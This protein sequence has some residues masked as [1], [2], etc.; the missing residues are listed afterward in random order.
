MMFFPPTRSGTAQTNV[1]SSP[2]QSPVADMSRP[3]S[4][5]LSR[6]NGHQLTFNPQPVRLDRNGESQHVQ[7][8]TLVE[9]PVERCV[10]GV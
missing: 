7:R 10:S 1:E 2:T 6:L 8:D 9:V 5:S 3:G 4:R